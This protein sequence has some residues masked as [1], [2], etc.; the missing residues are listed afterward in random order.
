MCRSSKS[1]LGKSDSRPAFFERGRDVEKRGE[2][3]RGRFEE[4]EDW[5]GVVVGVGAVM[6]GGWNVLTTSAYSSGGLLILI[7]AVC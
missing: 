1:L 3:G 7:L 5:D 6:L 4:R 2:D